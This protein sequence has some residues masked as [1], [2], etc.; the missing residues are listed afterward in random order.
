MKFLLIVYWLL[1]YIRNKI[2]IAIRRLTIIFFS[3]LFIE[4]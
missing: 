4:R 2:F 1:F 3:K